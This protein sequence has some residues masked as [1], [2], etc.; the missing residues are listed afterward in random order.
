MR[1]ALF[2]AGGQLGHSLQ[3]LQPEAV[4]LIALT[5]AELDI[6][7]EVQLIEKL[8]AAQ[9]DVIINAAAY[10][11]VDKAEQEPEKA[12][13]VNALGPQ[14]IARWAAKNGSRLLHIS[15]D[16]VFDGENLKTGFC[17]EILI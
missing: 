13:R 10:T 5:S 6:T 12:F 4:D 3:E 15:T 2:G 7:N 17:G 14:M 8:D 1:V 16:F 9:P 11:Q